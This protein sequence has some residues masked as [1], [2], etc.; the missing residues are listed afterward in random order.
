[1]IEF[2]KVEKEDESE[3]L[4]PMCD[5]KEGQVAFVPEDNGYAVMVFNKA[6]I[7]KEGEDPVTEGGSYSRGCSL[8][9]RVLPPGEKIIVSFSNKE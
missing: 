8:P 7:L 5:L 4:I 6:L 3:E 1:M 2:V 9:V